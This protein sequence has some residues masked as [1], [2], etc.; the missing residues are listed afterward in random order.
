M[1]RQRPRSGLT[2]SH[3]L[4]LILRQGRLG[5]YE[6]GDR[7]AIRRGADVVQT[8]VNAEHDR[9]GIAAVLAADA[10]FHVSL[11]F[12]SLL[13]GDLDQ[14]TDT[15][16]IEHRKRIFGKDVLLPVVA[17]ETSR[18]VAGEANL[19]GFP[20]SGPTVELAKTPAETWLLC[21]AVRL[22][23]CIRGRIV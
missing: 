19:L 13:Q 22:M 17:D 5:G 1:K 23:A 20:S 16:R 9:L 11:G 10:N 3:A 18:V 21:S 4:G 14:L 12:T 8:G 2:G 15:V 6:F 7:N